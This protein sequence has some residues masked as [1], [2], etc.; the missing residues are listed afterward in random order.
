MAPSWL[1]SIFDQYMRENKDIIYADYSNIQ[2]LAKKKYSSA[3]PITRIFVIGN[4]GAGKSSLV[5]ALKR[6][7]FFES[8]RRVSESSVP[9]H[10][11]GIVPSIHTSKH[12]GRSL[13]Y[14]FAGDP[15]Y[16]SSHAAILENLVSSKKGDNIFMIVVDLREENI[17]L[18]EILYYW[19]LIV[20]SASEFW[21]E[22]AM[23]HYHRKSFRQR[24]S[25]KG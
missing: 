11:A 21:L 20:H 18:R 19:L 15:E 4:P 10:T 6:E 3:E 23:P 17:K 24:D 5:E 12:Y 1:K 9:L 8:F 7:G 25:R 13:F 22:R 14:D 16:Y 2:T